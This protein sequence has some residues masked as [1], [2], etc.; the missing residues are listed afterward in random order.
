MGGLVGKVG[1][2]VAAAA[3]I[4]VWVR[5]LEWKTTFY[6]SRQLWCTP[7]EQALEYEEV[8]F[9]AEDACRLH[10]W[11]ITG[12]PKARG[13]VIV[14]H[15]NAGNIADRVWMAQAFTSLGLNV[16]LFDYRGYG[17]SAGIPT[18]RGLYRDARAAYEV[19]RARYGDVEDPPVIVYGRSLGAAVAVNLAAERAVR[20]VV[21]EGAFTR[22]RDMARVIYPW[23]PI[24][25]LLSQRFDSLSKIG[26]LGGVP[27]II[28]HSRDDEIVP[29][30]LGRALFD[31]APPPKKF[32][33]LRGSHNDCGWDSSPAYWSEI[34]RLVGAVLRR[35]D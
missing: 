35:G 14:C 12:P 18:E 16:F 26:L 32:C 20:G 34:R 25:W 21:L 4:W 2:W 30:E 9:V 6:P 33:E 22:A 8:H 1:I 29:F 5:M 3:L 13:A 23:L 19:V 28:A 24:G 7:A 31:A 10:G 11:W 17:R 27:K 15:G